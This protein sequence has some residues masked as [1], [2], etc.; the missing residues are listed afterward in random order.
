MKFV[1]LA[2]ECIFEHVYVLN[3]I[4]NLVSMCM[5]DCSVQVCLKNRNIILKCKTI[6]QKK[7]SRSYLRPTFLLKRN[8]KIKAEVQKGGVKGLYSLFSKLWSMNTSL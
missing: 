7:W 4:L 3:I 5:R 2:T 6:T 1:S 8:F